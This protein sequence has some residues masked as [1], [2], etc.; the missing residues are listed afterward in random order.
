MAMHLPEHFVNAVRDYFGNLCA[1][2]CIL[3]PFRSQTARAAA[4][5]GITEALIF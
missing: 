3:M 2:T 1:E 5:A 4:L